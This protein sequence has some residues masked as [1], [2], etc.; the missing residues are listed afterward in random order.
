MYA[1]LVGEANGNWDPL[2]LIDGFSYKLQ[3][4]STSEI[5]RL[6]LYGRRSID[7]AMVTTLRYE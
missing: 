3:C 6:M 5:K 7:S 2:E 1:V 4:R